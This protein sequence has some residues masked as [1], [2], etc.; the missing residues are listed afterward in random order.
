MFAVV[1]THL[2]VGTDLRQRHVR[3]DRPDR[4]I[5]IA[6]RRQLHHL[7]RRQR[8][9]TRT[10][11]TDRRQVHH[12]D[13][14]R[15]TRHTETPTLTRHQT[16]TRQPLPRIGHPHR[17][18]ITRI[19]AERLGGE[20]GDAV[21]D[22][23]DI[24]VHTVPET[25]EAVRTDRHERQVRIDDIRPE[26]DVARRRWHDDVGRHQLAVTGRR[27]QHRRQVDDRQFAIVERRRQRQTEPVA[28]VDLGSHRPRPD[29]ADG[30]HPRDGEDR[31]P[32]LR[33][34]S[35]GPETRRPPR[36]PS[37]RPPSVEVS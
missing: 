35:H 21:G 29:R 19:R 33:S 17:T 2:P 27:G 5:H 16:I 15:H 25:R 32:P 28:G 30:H 8:T 36:R 18:A 31:S 26:I 20:P 13:I 37:D 24:G 7:R 11:R 3:I 12:H 23:V 1:E 9:M 22:Q 34:G 14:T 4:E 10:R 6:H